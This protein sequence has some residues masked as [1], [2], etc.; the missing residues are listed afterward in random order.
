MNPASPRRRHLTW[1]IPAV[2]AVAALAFSLLSGSL[3]AYTASITNSNNTAGAGALTM[4]ETGPGADGNSVT[5]KSSEGSN[6]AA[7]C[8]TINKFG[9]K[10]KMSPG[11]TST[12]KI[13]LRNTGSINANTAVLT[14]GTCTNTP[15]STDLCSQLKV[16]ISEGA[17]QIFTG[18]AKDLAAGGAIT[19]TAPATGASTDYTIAVQLPANITNEFAGSTV[20]QP[21]TWT[22]TA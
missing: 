8:S 2:L 22:Y 17:K 11:Q 6:N 16:T 4:E 7:T 3:G 13:T 20:S 18:S 12:T 15:T 9:G 21:L 19:L 5:C 14:P 1:I 10:T